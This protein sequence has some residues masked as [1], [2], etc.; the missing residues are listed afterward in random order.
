MESEIK[1]KCL[2]IAKQFSNGTEELLRN[3][4]MLLE[5]VTGMSQTSQRQ[6]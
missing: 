2:E 1:M 4:K 5:F 6:S 3:A